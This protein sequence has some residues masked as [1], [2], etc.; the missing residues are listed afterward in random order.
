MRH[1]D[2]SRNDSEWE[3]QDDPVFA[4]RFRRDILICVGIGFLATIGLIAVVVNADAIDNWFSE[5][6]KAIFI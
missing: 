1:T 5:V 3:Y 6:L 4:Q 2:L